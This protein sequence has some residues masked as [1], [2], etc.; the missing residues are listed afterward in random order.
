MSNIIAKFSNGKIYIH[1][2]YE[3]VQGTMIVTEEQA[4]KLCNELSFAV[5]DQKTER[6]NAY[7]ID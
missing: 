5:A 1:W 3:D 6:R 4:E 7:L 2:F